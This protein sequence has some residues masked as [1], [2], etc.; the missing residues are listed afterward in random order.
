MSLLNKK[1]IGL[2][3]ADRSI[4][5]AEIKGAGLGAKVLNLSRIELEQGIVENGRIKD[6]DKLSLALQQVFKQAKPNAINN[7]EV[8][9]ALPE[10][11]V[12]VHNFTLTKNP[13]KTG[14]KREEQIVDE[15]IH[16]I[17]LEEH[18]LVYSFKILKE[19]KDSSEV[20]A[21]AA[22]KQVIWEWLDFF[23]KNKIQVKILD[24]EILAN[25]RDLFF[26]MPKNPVLVADIGAH[27]SSLA[28]FDEQGLH[29]EY[30]IHIA[31]DDFTK[32]IAKA[33]D[34]SEEKA[35]QE[36]IKN[37]L[38]IKNKKAAKALQERVDEV[39]KEVKNTLEF[40]KRE[41]N[42]TV[43]N[44]V[45]VGGSSMLS[46]LKDYFIKGLG[47][48]VQVGTAESLNT[49]APL[50][51]VEA[52]GL[53]R[54]ALEKKWDKTDPILPLVKSAPTSKKSSSEIKIVD[55]YMEEEDKKEQQASEF[56]KKKNIK[57][58]LLLL[59]IVVLLGVGLI[60]ISLW[61][62][63]DKKLKERELLQYQLQQI[64]GVVPYEDPTSTPS[65]EEINIFSTTTTPADTKIN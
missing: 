50:E 52:I 47:L 29:Y 19:E 4:E 34:C 26:S 13:G 63:N 1:S 38:K 11:Q 30:I 25:F 60:W 14:K 55:E 64:P 9:F 65:S 28:V 21:V 56:D 46:G 36:K 8:V 3:I 61:Y 62:R 31:G 12:Y 40:Y 35:D 2:D 39:V 16:N 51:F 20:L 37:G 17:P 27:T 48:S 54:R 57:S 44:M 33:L 59:C 24:V 23:D 22:S 18:D 43:T 15:I 32:A 41:T 42:T 6:L 58:Q 10:S 45:L 5:V 53:A 7:N 49:K